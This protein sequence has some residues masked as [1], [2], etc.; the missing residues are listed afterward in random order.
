M[1]QLL[2]SLSERWTGQAGVCLFEQ[3]ILL[4]IRAADPLETF[5]RHCGDAHFD[6]FYFTA[7]MAQLLPL[8]A[9]AGIRFEMLSSRR[10]TR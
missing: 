5:R 9:S 10:V 8:R 3:T 4:A 1:P 6:D 7:K 2:S